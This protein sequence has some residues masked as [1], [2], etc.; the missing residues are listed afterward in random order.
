[1]TA[2]IF[3]FPNKQ[4]QSKNKIQDRTNNQNSELLSEVFM[5]NKSLNHDLMEIFM[6]N[7]DPKLRKWELS[8]IGLKDLIQIQEIFPRDL[9]DTIKQL[10][11]SKFYI[12]EP[13]GNFEYTQ[14][15]KQEEITFSNY[16]SEE[17]GLSISKITTLGYAR[18]FELFCDRY[19]GTNEL[20]SDFQLFSRKEIIYGLMKNS[21]AYTQDTLKT[22][23]EFPQIT[24]T[25]LEYFLQF[26]CDLKFNDDIVS[27]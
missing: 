5:Y 18:F 25:N 2:K 22:V 27:Y 7:C 26:W 14:E 4:I 19:N 15:I 12:K 20:D 10:Q 1:M 16:L 13:S 11:N 6:Y 9:E 3:Q 23:Q 17:Y 8:H 24:E 21:D